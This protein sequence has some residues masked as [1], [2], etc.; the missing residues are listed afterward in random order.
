MDRSAFAVEA[1]TAACRD[2]IVVDRRKPADRSKTGDRSDQ[3]PGI[4]SDEEE[5]A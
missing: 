1:I 2:I 3:G 5:A 4:S